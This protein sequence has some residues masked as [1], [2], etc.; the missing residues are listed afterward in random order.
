[1]RTRFIGRA[2]L[3]AEFG[4][5]LTDL[6]AGHGAAILLGGEPGIG[7][8]SLVDEYVRIAES[9]GVPVLYG[10]AVEDSG[11][12]PY[13]P[14]TGL[15]ERAASPELTPDLLTADDTADDSPATRQRARFDVWRRTTAAL[16][17]AANSRGLVVVIDDLHWADELS[18]LLVRHICA[19]IDRMPLLFVGAYRDRDLGAPLVL[20]RSLAEIVAMPAAYATDLE[21]L[22]AD[23]VAAYVRNVA[24]APVADA[25]IRRIHARTGG[26]ALF[27][28]E[29][30]RLLVQRGALAGPVADP[31]LPAELRRLLAYQLGRLTPACRELVDACAVIGDEVDPAL[32]DVLLDGPAAISEA[33]A[34]GVLVEADDGVGQPRFSHSLLREVAYAE[35]PHDRRVGWHA[36][37]AAHLDRAAAVDSTRLGE[38][39]SH[40]VRAVTGAE[41]ARSALA[42]CRDAAAHAVT[43]LAFDDAARWYAAALGLIPTAGGGDQTRARLLLDLAAVDYWSGQVTSALDRCVEAMELA[44]RLADGSVA[45]A[46]AVQVQG[47]G[48]DP[49]RTIASLCERARALLSKAD[50]AL[51]A[52]VLAAHSRALGE[53]AEFDAAEELSRE[54][55][56]VAEQSA[57]PTAM[58]EAMHARHQLIMGPDGV[59]E[60]LAL[61][62]RLRDLAGQPGDALWGHLW[63]LTAAFE[64][65][66]MPAV[67]SEIASLAALVDRYGWPLA[68]WHMLRAQASRHLLVGHFAEAEELTVRARDSV[69]GTQD[70]T[71]TALFLSFASTLAR[72]TGRFGRHGVEEAAESVPPVPVIMAGLAHYFLVAGDLDRAMSFYRVVRP[73]L[74]SLRKD[75]AFLAVLNGVSAVAVATGDLAAAEECYEHL[76]PYG[77]VYNN[78]VQGCAGSVSRPLG[79]LAAALGKAEAADRH[80]TDAVAMERR[81]GAV[82]FLALAQLEHAKVLASQ[83]TRGG[84]RARELLESCLRVAR[85]LGMAPTVEAATALQERLTAGPPLTRREREIA[86]LIADGLSNRQIAERFVLSERTVETHVRSVLSKL[87]LGNR[88]HVAAWVARGGLR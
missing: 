11:A 51:Y 26:N 2:G 42:A 13:W 61:G 69:A 65:G 49:N 37:L 6:R 24:G 53:L 52:R 87:Q 46:A 85:R 20:P 48:G 3:V 28:R 5:R 83:G 77:T 82:P 12:P 55:L 74:P 31:P 32:L 16:A 72:L 39:A 73:H 10:R 8:S 9:D 67:D 45:A 56:L 47:I 57:E 50:G 79:M 38:R 19:D 18:L 70:R 22:A 40:W 29:L 88:T 15:L 80:L 78:A 4:D 59:A 76:L 60:R 36:R 25:W 44:E 30:T 23:D 68:R 71:A 43:R 14:W 41:S 27:V 81:I 63:R 75:V 21:P 84:E 64:V 58:A 17:K 33:V 34:A 86:Q 54:A 62:A 1:M 66:T 35:L 7:K